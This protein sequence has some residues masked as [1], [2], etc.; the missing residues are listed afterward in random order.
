MNRFESKI[1]EIKKALNSLSGEVERINSLSM[2]ID[3]VGIPDDLLDIIPRIM[4]HAKSEI[5]DIRHV[6]FRIKNKI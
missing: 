4:Y 1:K 2:D 5:E 6:L 3:A